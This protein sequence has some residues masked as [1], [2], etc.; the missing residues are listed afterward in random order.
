MRHTK[1]GP[2]NR[3]KQTRSRQP[4]RRVR[5]Q[6]TVGDLIAAAFD[7]VGNEV[8]GVATLVSSLSRRTGARI[9]LV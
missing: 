7:T 6:T 8:R 2:I 5:I 1:R 3:G 9:V 4:G